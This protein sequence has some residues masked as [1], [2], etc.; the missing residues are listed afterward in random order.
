LNQ[1]ESRGN[2]SFIGDAE[3][4][5]FDEEGFLVNSKKFWVK[6]K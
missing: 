2:L 6:N 4:I 1:I 5:K 3:A